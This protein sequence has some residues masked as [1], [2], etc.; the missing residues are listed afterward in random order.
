MYTLLGGEFKLCNGFLKTKLEESKDMA[1]LPQLERKT[2]LEA[3]A[4]LG[5]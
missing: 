1:A 2:K 4:D 5:N 3:G